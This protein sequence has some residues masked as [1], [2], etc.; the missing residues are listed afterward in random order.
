MSAFLSGLLMPFGAWK[1]AEL[2]FDLTAHCFKF[3]SLERAK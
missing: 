2:I 3:F 1:I